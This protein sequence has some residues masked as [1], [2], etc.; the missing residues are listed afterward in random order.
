[1]DELLRA[2]QNGLPSNTNAAFFASE[3]CSR[4]SA[5][6]SFE[7]TTSPYDR[8]PRRRDPSGPDRSGQRNTGW[9]VGSDLRAD[10][11]PL[12]ALNL[13][14]H[15]ATGRL[16]DA[17]LPVPTALGD[18]TQGGRVRSPS[19]PSAIGRFEFRTL[20][21][22]R[23]PRRCD[24]TGPDRSGRRNTERRRV[25]S[26]SGPSAIGRREFRTSSCNRSPRRC[27]P[28]GPDRSGRRNTERR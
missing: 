22:N 23:S 19:G 7:L 2:V 6:G 26:P 27:D 5:I 28:A 1:M 24:P 14:P 20:P 3:S 17:T 8:S 21:Y 10:R 16:G 12:V 11:Q 4:P 25:R 18:A 9:P 13:G 15:R